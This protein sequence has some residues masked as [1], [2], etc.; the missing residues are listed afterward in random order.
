MVYR[1][2]KTCVQSKSRHSLNLRWGSNRSYE[3]HSHLLWRHQ[4]LVDLIQCRQYQIDQMLP[5]DLWGPNWFVW[6][7]QSPNGRPSLTPRLRLQWK[8]PC[9]LPKYFGWSILSTY[10]FQD[11][12]LSPQTPFMF[13]SKHYHQYQMLEH[14]NSK[15]IFHRRKEW[16]NFWINPDPVYVWRLLQL[17]RVVSLW[18]FI[19]L[20]LS[21][22]LFLCHKTPLK[23]GA[24]RLICHSLL[25]PS[26]K[27]CLECKHLEILSR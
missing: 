18:L 8:I 11:Q 2:Y 3:Y 1:L 15:G 26:D 19:Q 4:D 9:S 24:N 10:L 23:F 16:R 22:Q 17:L 12:K 6:C 21:C 14:K 25:R 5:H 27:L 20:M 13:Y 7:S